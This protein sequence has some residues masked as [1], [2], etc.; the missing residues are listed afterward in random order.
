MKKDNSV[1][2]MTCALGGISLVLFVVVIGSVLLMF[3]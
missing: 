2:L 3:W 1:E